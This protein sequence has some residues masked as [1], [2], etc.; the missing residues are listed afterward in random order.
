MSARL[1]RDVHG[2]RQ[3]GLH[4]RDIDRMHENLH[5]LLPAETEARAIY[6]QETR[7]S[8]LQNLKSATGT[9]PQL[10]HTR[11]PTRITLNVGDIGP[12]ACTQHFQRQE[13]IHEIARAFGGDVIET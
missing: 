4:N 7:P 6:L 8:G 2:R 10:R 11:D 3:G 13:L 12:L 1:Q 5:G 9:D